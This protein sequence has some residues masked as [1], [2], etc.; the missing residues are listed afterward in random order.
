M[1]KAPS[2]IS[3]EKLD[4]GRVYEKIVGDYFSKRGWDVEMYTSKDENGN[5]TS[6]SIIIDTN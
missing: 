4:S 1:K 3:K 6:Q 5:E 2:M